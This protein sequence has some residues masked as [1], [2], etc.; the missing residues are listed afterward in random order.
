MK[1][2]KKI[3]FVFVSIFTV[4]LTTNVYAMENEE[5]IGV[6]T[7]PP[8]DIVEISDDSVSERGTSAPSNSNVW[9]WSNG[10]YS[11]TGNTSNT[12][13]YTNYLFTGVTTLNATFTKAD[14]SITIEVW[15]RTPW[16]QS[17][18]KRGSK[19]IARL[20]ADNISA[21]ITRLASFTGL[22][23]SS[24]YYLKILAPAHFIASVSY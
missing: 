13:L 12:N 15:E 24:K 8:V 9:S 16:Y 22:T 10:P 4:T 14:E 20:T 23:S 18:A 1:L 3:L 7:N 5:N 11:M 19:T 2:L 6:S 17:D 21:G